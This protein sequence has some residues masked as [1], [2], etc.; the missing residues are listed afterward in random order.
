M[1]P[2]RIGLTSLLFITLLG[3]LSLT[4][5]TILPADP[6]Q[7]RQALMYGM[8]NRDMG[9][10]TLLGQNWVESTQPLG[11]LLNIYTPY[12]QVATLVLRSNVPLYPISEQDIT[13][14]VTKYQSRINTIRKENTAKFIV[15]LT[16]NTPNFCRTLE[17]RLIGTSTISK[18]P[19]WLQPLRTENPYYAEIDDSSGKRVYSAIS[20]VFFT[21]PQLAELTG[22][23][24]LELRTKEHRNQPE[25]DYLFRINT[26]ALR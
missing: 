13:N 18:K 21:Q 11:N 23:A 9:Y 25:P 1:K 3:T 10:S 8:N 26:D 4:Q 16:G 20:K 5:A 22:E 12:M 24:R 7:T 17:A 19:L 14:A 2:W 15:S 6:A